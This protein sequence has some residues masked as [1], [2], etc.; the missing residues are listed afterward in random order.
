MSES[1][2][3]QNEESTLRAELDGSIE[4]ILSMLGSVSHG[5]LTG[6]L[7]LGFPESHPAGALAQSVNSMIEA[8]GRAREDSAHNLHELSERISLIERQREAIQT[9]SVPV[10][11]IWTGVLCVPVIGVLDS[12]RAADIT[13]TL[14]ST[15]VR[16]KARYA[17]IDLTG[18][19]IM[20]T[21]SADY[22]LRMARAVTLL[23]SKCALSGIHPNIARTIIHMG[24]ELE[25]LKSFRS[26][27]DA[28][29]F[30]VAR[31]LR[32]QTK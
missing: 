21:Q 6:R 8:L 7:N 26:M 30:C 22:F 23:G 13:A 15:I 1:D 5:D 28:L 16:K 14:L 4:A 2:G 12:G 31:D 10:I 11:E 25:G 9:L 29:K 24:L 17:I 3:N 18:L 20:D 19:E 27:R 32:L